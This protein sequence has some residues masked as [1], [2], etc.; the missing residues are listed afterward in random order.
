MNAVSGPDS[1]E[2]RMERMVSLYQLSLLRMCVLYLHDE[3]LARNAVQETFMSAY[4]NLDQ[5]IADSSEQL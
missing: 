3:E 5:F 2:E 1:K 4:R